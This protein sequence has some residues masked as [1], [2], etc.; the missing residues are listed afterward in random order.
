MTDLIDRAAELEQQQRE[1]ALQSAL[2]KPL[3]SQEIDELGNYYCN[4]CGIQIPP[5]RIAAVPTAVCCIDC[6]TIRE[7]IGKHFV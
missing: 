3:E 1:Q 2:S 4:D 7:R 6:Q 5:K